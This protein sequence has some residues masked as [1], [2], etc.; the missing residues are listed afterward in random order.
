MHFSKSL[1]GSKRAITICPVSIELTLLLLEFTIKDS[2]F[3][4]KTVRLLL[5]LF[6]I[7]LRACK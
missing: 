7:N 4:F 2:Y 6:V 3:L 5:T 1:Q